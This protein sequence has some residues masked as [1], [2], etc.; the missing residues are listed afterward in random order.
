METMTPQAMAPASF[1]YYS[2]DPN[3]E[4]RQHGHFTAHPGY[5]QHQLQ[6]QHQHP[7]PHQLPQQMPLYP[8]VPTLPSTPIYSRPSSSCSQPPMHPKAYSAVLPMVASP[9]PITHKPT[10]VLETELREHSG[11]Y[12]PSTPP[13]S[14]SGSTISSPGSCDLLQTPMNPMFSGLEA[15]GGKETVNAEVKPE[16][17]ANLDW[18]SC[19][20]PPMTPGE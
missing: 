6:L 18:S 9:Q 7:H 16:S 5:Q 14:T 17:F 8:V 20:S 3:P 15:F 12:Y 4:N 19:A 10:I 2:P 1:Y 13:L 11:L